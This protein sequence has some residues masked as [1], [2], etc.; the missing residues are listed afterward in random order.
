MF[1]DRIPVFTLIHPTI[2]AKIQANKRTLIRWKVYIDRARMYIGYIQF[3]MIGFVFLEAYRDTQ[4]GLLI[5]DNLLYSIPVI[6][7]LFVSLSLIVGRLDTA[8]GLREEE[9]RNSSSNNPV[10]RELLATVKELRVEVK[11]LKRD[12]A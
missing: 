1:Y 7:V 9:L 3:L 6:F 10:M 2:M 8:F 5:F 11:E 4:F 12:Q